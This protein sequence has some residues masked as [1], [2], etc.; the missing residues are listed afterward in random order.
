[1]A[2]VVAVFFVKELLLLWQLQILLVRCWFLLFMFLDYAAFQL[3]IVSGMALICGLGVVLL[4][5]VAMLMLMFL[6]VT[7]MIMLLMSTLEEDFWQDVHKRDVRQRAD[8]D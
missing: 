5:P 8:S 7:K 4:V 2:M 3:M 1:M 6:I